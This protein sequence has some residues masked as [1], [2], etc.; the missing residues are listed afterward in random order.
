[1]KEGTH[2]VRRALALATAIAALATPAASGATAEQLLPGAT[3]DGDVRED[4]YTPLTEAS[5]SPA[6]ASADG[7]DWGDAGIGA[8]AV[9]AV[10]AMLAGG[11]LVLRHRPRQDPIA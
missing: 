10:A 7:F 1:M 2:R 11:T 3:G 9:V 4:A 5:S 6:S 8:T